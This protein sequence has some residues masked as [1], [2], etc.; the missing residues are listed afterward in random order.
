LEN[1]AKAS[2]NHIIL[3]PPG[4]PD[5]FVKIGQNIAHPNFCHNLYIFCN[6]KFGPLLYFFICRS[7]QSPNRRKFAQNG[8][9]VSTLSRDN[10]LFGEIE[11]LTALVY[12]STFQLFKRTYFLSM[13]LAAIEEFPSFLIKLY[14]TAIKAYVHYCKIII[15]I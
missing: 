1:I 5:E 8:H 3:F 2:Q 9:P 6:F 12:V 11:W 4:W 15:I 7:K 13:P 10:K 14:K